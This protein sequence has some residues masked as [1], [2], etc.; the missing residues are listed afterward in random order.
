MGLTLRTLAG[1]LLPAIL[2][3][4]ALVAIT[5][6]A[7]AVTFFTEENPP[8]NFIKDGQ[9]TGVATAVV[10]E[11]AKRAGVPADVSV[12][13]WAQSYAQALE[14]REACVF[15]TV[16]TAERTA[17]FQ[18]VGPIARGEWSVFGREGFP[19]QAKKVD[20]LKPFRL[21]VQNDARVGF[22]RSRGFG[23]LVVAE[24]PLDL[25]AML[26]PDPKQLGR[27]DLWMTQTIGAADVARS[28][29]V[30]DLKLVFA[31]LMNQD[32]W[33]ACNTRLAPETIKGYSDALSGMRKDGTFKQLSTPAR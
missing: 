9:V 22:L 6:P 4:V 24:H 12:M 25:A 8:L 2:G 32:Y 3:L 7:R 28:A 16:R 26:T 29:G 1:S 15:S 27:I 11:M 31:G 33:L 13:P 30:T 17:L 23:N 18:W 5:A 20:D 21:G 14:N 19:L 10:R